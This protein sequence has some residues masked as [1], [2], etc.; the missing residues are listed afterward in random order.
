MTFKYQPIPNIHSYQLPPLGLNFPFNIDIDIL[1]SL[2]YKS[3][4]DILIIKGRQQEYR[5]SNLCC[6]WRYKLIIKDRPGLIVRIPITYD[7]KSNIKSNIKNK[8]DY[9]LSYR[10]YMALNRPNFISKDADFIYIGFEVL[11]NTYIDNSILIEKG[12]K[13]IKEMLELF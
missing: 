3:I 2:E 7:N 6:F 8:D 5:E 9:I 12:V 10:T 1:A 4:P 11:L 13:I